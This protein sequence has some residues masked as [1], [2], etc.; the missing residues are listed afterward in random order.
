MALA[1]SRNTGLRAAIVST[2]APKT[3][4]DGT[5]WVEY[6]PD[7]FCAIETDA[8]PRLVIDDAAPLPMKSIPGSKLWYGSVG[9]LQVGKAHTFH[10]VV[11]GGDF[12]GS[13]DV[14][15][16]SAMSYAMPNVPQGKLSEKRV[17]I[18]KMY[19]GMKSDYWVYIPAE[20]DP[21]VPAALMVIQDGESY[22]HRDGRLQA[23]NVFDNLIA[24]KKIPV[25]VFVMVNPGDITDSPGTPTF[26]FVSRFAEEHHRNLKDAMRSTLYDTVS[27]RYVRFLRD[28]LLPE[29][30]AHLNVRKDAYSHAIA[31]GS[32]GGICAFNAAWQMPEEFSRV[33]IWVGSFTALQWHE[34]PD[35]TE[36]GQDYPDLVLRGPKRNIRVWT[37]D[38]ANDLDRGDDSWPL[39]NLRMANALKLRD[40][41]FH[42]SFGKGTHNVAQGASEFPES[43]TWL[44]RDYDPARTQQTFEQDDAEKAKPVFRVAIVNR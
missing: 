43:L 19:D 39:N 20:Y 6:G 31:G 40:Y 17:N 13:L 35:I 18:S 16:L 28:E 9:N 4:H 2:F 34:R 36:G 37:Q 27:D 5:A 44:W 26:E 30:L 33:Q 7:F 12:G 11:D 38:G 15:G 8:Q 25:T 23:L 32:S 10:Y 1:A 42:F 3:L 14:P 24:A 41:D 22:T 29:A 21:A